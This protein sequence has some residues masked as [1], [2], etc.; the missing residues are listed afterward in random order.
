MENVLDERACLARSTTT[1]KHDCHTFEPLCA[2]GKRLGHASLLNGKKQVEAE[3]FA[4]KLN[5]TISLVSLR[6]YPLAFASASMVVRTDEDMPNMRESDVEPAVESGRIAAGECEPA[7]IEL[8]RPRPWIEWIVLLSS[9]TFALAMV[10]KR[11]LE[12]AARTAVIVH[13]N[14]RNL[15]TSLGLA[16]VLVACSQNRI[17]ATQ[18]N[19]GNDGML[20]RLATFALAT[21]CMSRAIEVIYA[22][23]RDAFAKL[24][25]E[26]SES[27]LDGRQRIGL[28]LTSYVELI[29]NFAILLALAPAAAWQEKNANRPT[30]VIDVLFYSGSTITTSGGGGYVP[31]GVIVQALTAFE[32]ACGLILL[33]VCFAVYAGNPSGSSRRRLS[34]V[35]TKQD[36]TL[37]KAS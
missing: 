13:L 11:G 36:I 15:F 35:Q 37:G 12:G 34:M 2:I 31:K 4:F 26:G 3:Y 9:W 16:T 14:R 29:L 8:L 22:F 10:R 24:A 25:D 19:V 27:D 33:V 32:I 5:I 17:A 7:A 20:F 1:R 28:A 18:W 21:Y 6:R 23:C 30:H